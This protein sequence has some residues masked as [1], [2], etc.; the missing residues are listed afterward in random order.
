MSD[1][2]RRSALG[3]RLDDD[4]D[5]IEAPVTPEETAEPVPDSPVITRRRALTI[6]GA[7]P[8]IGPALLDAQAKQAPHRQSHDTPNQPAKPTPQPKAAQAK[9]RFFT[10]K[11]LRTVRVLGDDVIP[12]D[13]RSG[14]ASEA[15]VPAF[16][17][18]HLSVEE[19][20]P[21][22][23]LAWRGGL[24]W[25]DNESNRRFGVAYAT[26]TRAQR[27]QIL[28]DIAYPDRVRPEMRAGAA[29]F[30]R[31]RDMCAAGFFSSAMGWKDLQYM[32]HTFVPVWN[33]CPEPAL[34]KLDV[35]Y[36]LMDTRI[37]TQE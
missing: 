30:S 19:T 11:E 17:D 14:S 29:F 26:A 33:G 37:P 31:F 9:R 15:G 10:A 36:D 1:G 4:G 18:F 34:R 25:M 32:G 21:E 20:S 16:I 12:R 35:S 13:A 5:S 3:A 7:L 23:R 27:H 22:V 6:L 24:R 28:E 8:V 2:S